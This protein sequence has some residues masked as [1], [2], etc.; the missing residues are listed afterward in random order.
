MRRAIVSMHLAAIM[1][2]LLPVAALPACEGA[3][4]PEQTPNRVIIA[5]LKAIGRGDLDAARE[6]VAPESA[7][8]IESWARLLFFPDHSTPPTPKEEHDVDRFIG[9]FYRI[10][11]ME[12]TETE[13]SLH[14]VFVA[15]D[16]LIGFPAVADDPLVPS[17]APFRVTLVRQFVGGGEDEAEGEGSKPTGW[18]ITSWTPIAE[19]Y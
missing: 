2:A 18:L 3:L 19:K 4:S 11:V 14:V 13:A 7:D 12:E 5:F 1:A 16:A 10:T 6:F 15:T 17:S 9:L 8:R